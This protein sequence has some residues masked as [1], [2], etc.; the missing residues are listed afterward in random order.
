M[1]IDIAYDRGIDVDDCPGGNGDCGCGGDNGFAS[2]G[3][4]SSASPTLRMSLLSLA[5]SAEISL[6][7]TV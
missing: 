6:H 5:S 4:F 2:A 3:S 7:R 1:V